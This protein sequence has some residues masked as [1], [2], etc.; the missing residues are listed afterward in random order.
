[1]VITREYDGAFSVKQNE[2]LSELEKVLRN[3][4]RYNGE[5]LNLMAALMI[6]MSDKLGQGCVS[7][8]PVED[9]DGNVITLVLEKLP[10]TMS[11]HMVD[12]IM[13]TKR[14]EEALEVA[15]EIM[16]GAGMVK[17]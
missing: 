3:H 2:I 10:A 17:K 13:Q 4:N 1:M 12:I 5:G 9:D 6:E 11:R 14:A 16:A 7:F 8:D 15:N